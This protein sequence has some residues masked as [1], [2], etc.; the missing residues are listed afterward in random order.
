MLQQIK[1]KIVWNFILFIIKFIISYIK[2]FFLTGSVFFS[3]AI[4]LFIVLN[5]NPNFSF[6]FL[7]YFSFID[8][9]YK[10]GTFRGGLEEIMEIFSVVS[11]VFMIVISLVKIAL[12]KIFKLNISI[13]FKSKI[14]V[15]F[16]TI[17][18]AYIFASIIVSFSDN[19]DKGFYFVFAIFYILNL[20]SIAFYFIVDEFLKRIVKFLETENIPDGKQQ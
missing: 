6:S 3:I 18:L 2:Y 17:T 7:Q 19:L 1:N 14:I 20:V 16:A 8:P 11:F 13:T 10:T 12:Q 5:M 4:L 15:F 9:G